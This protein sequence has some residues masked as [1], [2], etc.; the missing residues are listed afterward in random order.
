MF[1]I[2]HLKE[3]DYNINSGDLGYSHDPQPYLDTKG[4]TENLKV[5]V[6][7]CCYKQTMAESASLLKFAIVCQSLPKQ[8]LA[9]YGKLRQTLANFD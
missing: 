1:S 6:G 4:L 2:Y 5:V 8:T 7:T 3:L 9:N